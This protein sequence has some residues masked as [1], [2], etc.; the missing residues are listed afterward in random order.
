MPGIKVRDAA[1]KLALSCKTLLVIMKEMGLAERSYSSYL[2]FEEYRSIKEKLKE[3]KERFKKDLLFKGE[4][5]PSAIKPVKKEFD[6]TIVKER[7]RK[8]LTALERKEIVHHK[9][10]VKREEPDSK[11]EIIKI[12]PYMTVAELAHAFGRL[13]SELIKKCLEMGVITTINQRLD[14]E[15]EIL[16][17][18]AFGCEVEVEE[19]D[20]GFTEA[21]GEKKPRPPVVVVIGHVDHGKTTLLDYIRKT[22]VAEKEAG[23]ITQQVGAY[24]VN[25]KE[26]KI[27]FLDTPGHEA[28]TAM[29]ARGVQLTDI[30]VLVVAADEGVMPQTEEAINHARAASCPIIV[31]ITK[32]DKPGA[33]PAWVKAQLAEK[34]VRVE[35]YGGDVICVETSAYTGEGIDNLLYAI[36]LVTEGIEPKAVYD[37]EARGVIIDSHM[38]KGR[39][40]VATVLVQEGTLRKGDIFV[41][42]E[43]Y[44]RVRDILSDNFER[45]PSATPGIPV[46]ILGF[47]GQPEAGERFI[48]VPDEWQAKEIASKKAMAKRDRLLHFQKRLTLE[49]LQEK[50]KS[51]ETKEL[52]LIL[53]GNASGPVEALKSALE[54]LSLKDVR[55]KII[56]S[57]VGQITKSDVLLAEAS[58]GIIIGYNTEPLSEARDYAESHGVEIRCYKV[59]YSA[60][61]DIRAAML[62]LLEPV[63]KESLVGKVRIKKVFR[64]PRL[65]IVLGGMVE[66][67]KIVKGAIGRVFRAGKEIFKGEISSLKRFK[68]D[69]SVVEAGYECG[70]GIPNI[71]D[72]APDDI[73]E[74][75]VQ[76]EVKREDAL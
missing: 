36:H 8:T 24:V 43:L 66:E 3:E 65:G 50:I 4:K 67:G 29:R 30:A 18:D 21:K 72:C 58:G 9:R 51:G 62:G 57:G 15:T 38:E 45:L 39:G 47:S 46:Q 41:C 7:V 35:G 52:C 70:I 56:H 31:C 76:E 17:A 54:G 59:I 64:I 27:T 5:K 32:I 60:I 11:K 23:R 13:P 75:Y 73:L 69:V 14:L 48:V 34:G 22:K 1:K 55:I 40:W 33:N 68:D 12:T 44:G 20:F 61:D 2:S 19:I 74:V 63:L 6:S 71:E 49:S 16:L 10:K 28:F 42:G 37:T 53:K 25:F 26:G